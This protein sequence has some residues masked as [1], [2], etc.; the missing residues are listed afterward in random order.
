MD[1]IDGVPTALLL[2]RQYRETNPPQTVNRAAA[3][4][5]ISATE[6]ESIPE[7][8]YPNFTKGKRL[9]HNAITIS[10]KNIVLP[11]FTKIFSNQKPFL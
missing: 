2:K 7:Y 9:P 4:I 6:A 11:F 1:F 5:R 10:D 8:T 3:N